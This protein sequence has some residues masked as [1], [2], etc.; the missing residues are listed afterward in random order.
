MNTLVSTV[1]ILEAT[2]VANLPKVLAIPK[3]NPL[4]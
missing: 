3:A 1:M 2:I 4:I